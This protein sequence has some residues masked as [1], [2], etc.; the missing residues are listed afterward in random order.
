MKLHHVDSIS[1]EQII[2]CL[3]PVAASLYINVTLMM[4]GEGDCGAAYAKAVMALQTAF[5]WRLCF[6]ARYTLLIKTLI[7]VLMRL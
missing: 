1:E 5:P 6:Q 2:N 4:G 3:H 7:L